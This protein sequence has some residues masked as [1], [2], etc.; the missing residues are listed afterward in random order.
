[1]I[2]E[3]ALMNIS[4]KNI[5]TFS[6]AFTALILMTSNVSDVNADS[7][8]FL[9]CHVGNGNEFG[10][11]QTLE[12]N[13]NGF[14]GHD[15]H[16]YDE[17]GACDPLK[18]I[19]TDDDG[20]SDY[21]DICPED[22]TNT[23]NDQRDTTAPIVE[24]DLVCATDGNAGYCLGDVTLSW[25][26][27]EN[28][29]EV[30]TSGCEQQ[31]VNYDTTGISFTC[32]ASSEGGN[33]DA[34]VTIKRDA[35]APITSFVS[36]SPEANVNG[37]NNSSV[38]VTFACSDE[39]SGVDDDS[40]VV[41]LD[42]EGAGQSAS[43]TCEDIAGNTSENTIDRINID[44]TA[45]TFSE[46]SE[47]YLLNEPVNVSCDD[48]LS[49]VETCDASIATNGAGQN[50][51]IFSAVDLAGNASDKNVSYAVHYQLACQGSDGGFLSPIDNTQ[52][53]VGRALPEKFVA[54]DYYDN[55]VSTVE[56]YSFYGK[57]ASN[58]P[59]KDS[60]N[61]FKYDEV[62]NQYI[63]VWNTKG[64]GAGVHT[65]TAELDSG[66]EISIDLTFEDKKK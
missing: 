17:L 55:P 1:M 11:G 44:M 50:D 14:K 45:P 7:E 64:I 5:A 51:A 8:K 36:Q 4:S 31:V 24:Y 59:G 62:D 37:W 66:Q 38:D 13:E 29:S 65:I 25:I 30:T 33:S 48:N 3:I 63:F 58:G 26:V 34:T 9:I 60:T 56:A 54:C 32:T 61:Q 43:A 39:T 18:E 47:I 15:D 21:D 40:K 2:S 27:T 52:Y 6:I 23:C 10:V 41:T 19:D 22:A 35:T 12:V 49:G 20:I 53:K 57:V 16:E 28:E 46:I 42:T